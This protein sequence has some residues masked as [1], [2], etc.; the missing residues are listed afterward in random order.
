MWGSDVKMGLKV[1]SASKAWADLFGA[2]KLRILH[3]DDDVAFLSVAKQVL[4]DNAH[5]QVETAFSAEEAL[6]KLRMSEYDVV[7]TDYQMPGKNGL[8]LIREVRGQG[9][10]VPFIV[11]SCK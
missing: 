4:E 3:V 5:F 11:F 6:Q 8:E 9:N 7:I 2:K 1:D 10:D